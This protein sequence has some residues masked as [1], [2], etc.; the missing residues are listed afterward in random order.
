MDECQN[1]SAQDA[2][3]TE[4][5]CGDH[6]THRSYWTHLSMQINMKKGWQERHAAPKHVLCQAEYAVRLSVVNTEVNLYVCPHGIDSI[7]VSTSVCPIDASS[8]TDIT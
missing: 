7:G 2:V 6:R 1:D 3:T 4:M 8:F 5:M